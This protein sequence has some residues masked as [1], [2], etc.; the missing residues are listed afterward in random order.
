M[1]V[2]LVSGTKQLGVHVAVTDGQRVKVLE[3]DAVEA[4]LGTI[5]AE[6][7]WKDRGSLEEACGEGMDDRS[8]EEIETLAGRTRRLA[9]LYCSGTKDGV[10]KKD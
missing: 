1:R 4:V 3:A 7:S 9:R 6:D 5:L 2:T 8:Q 10:T